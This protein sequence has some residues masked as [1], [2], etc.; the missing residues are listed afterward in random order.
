MHHHFLSHFVHSFKLQVWP[1]LLDVPFRGEVRTDELGF[2]RV[3]NRHSGE[4]GVLV[5]G[6]RRTHAPCFRSQ[7]MK[8]VKTVRTFL[9][10][11][12]EEGASLAEYGLLIA[13]IAVVCIAAITL[14]G[15][16]IRDMF[17]QLAGAIWCRMSGEVSGGDRLTG[18][19]HR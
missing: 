13:L 1:L 19:R 14:L 16:S 18:T 2:R 11:K 3:R 7:D 4:F 9:T 12:E 17:N 15:T 6:T 10:R 8:L 5:G